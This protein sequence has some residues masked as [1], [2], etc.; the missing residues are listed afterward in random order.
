MP[1][2]RLAAGAHCKP[3][4]GVL[5]ADGDWHR[6]VLDLGRRLEKTG[7]GRNT[8]WPVF[9]GRPLRLAGPVY[10]V[11]RAPPGT[12]LDFDNVEFVRRDWRGA[13]VEIPVPSFSERRPRGGPAGGRQSEIVGFSLL[14]DRRPD[15]VPPETVT[16]A[17]SPWL[18]GETF[19]LRSL[20]PFGRTTVGADRK[21]EGSGGLWYLHVR[22]V[23]GAGN[24]SEAGHLE[25]DFGGR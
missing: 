15:T 3:G 10:L 23:D 21:D 11:G 2:G 25:A 17:A 19:R 4:G 12:E 7:E 22:S 16:H 13:V 20:P 6:A 9:E 14:W 8:E 1:D 24:W 18:A 5:V